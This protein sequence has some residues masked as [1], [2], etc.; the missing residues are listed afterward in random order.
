MQTD[1]NFENLTE[2]LVNLFAYRL[3]KYKYIF[4][5]YG[6]FLFSGVYPLC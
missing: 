2:Q 3:Y 1:N 5:N 6:Y 4:N